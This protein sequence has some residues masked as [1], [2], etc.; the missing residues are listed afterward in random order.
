MS[1][2]EKRILNTASPP[3]GKDSGA[4][5]SHTPIGLSRKLQQ[6]M[7]Q[8]KGEF[9]SADGKGVDYGSLS[10]SEVFTQYLQL[11]EELDGTDISQLSEAERKAF[12]ISILCVCVCV[13]VSAVYVCVYECVCMCECACVCAYVHVSVWVCACVHV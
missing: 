7:L 10:T 9:M 13:C 3:G 11:A 12:F 6:T 2:P 8:M 4:V 5:V 1:V